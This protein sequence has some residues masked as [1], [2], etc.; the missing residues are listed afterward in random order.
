MQVVHSRKVLALPGFLGVAA[1]LSEPRPTSS[2]SAGIVD[3]NKP[4]VTTAAGSST[5][6]QR[7]FVT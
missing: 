3:R 2:H 5:V 6:N 4:L 7:P 1:R